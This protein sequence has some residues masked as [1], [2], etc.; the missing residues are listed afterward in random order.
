M[1][2]STSR[3]QFPPGGAAGSPDAW[4]SIRLGDLLSQPIR[5]GYSPVCGDTP[6]GRWVLGLGALG[7]AGVEPGGIK[8]APSDDHRVLQNELRVG[9]FLV[10]RSNT[11][12]KVGRASMWRGEVDH[13]SYP[14][15]MMRFRVDEKLVDPDYLEVYLRSKA[16]RLHFERS[17]SGTSGSM[18]KINKRALET[19]PVLLPPLPEQKR[20]A[21]A[22]ATWDRAVATL[23][24]LVQAKR[25]AH[26]Y[27]IEKLTAPSE[28]FGRQWHEYTLGELFAVPRRE[29]VSDISTERLVTVRLHCNG[30]VANDTVVPKSTPN[31]RQYFRRHTGE[32]LVGRQNLH[33]GGFGV[34]P[35]HLD[36]RIA[37]SAITSLVPSAPDFVDL[38]FV[39]FAM[40][41]PRWLHWVGRNADGTGQKEL[42]ER[43][44]LRLRISLP[45]IEYQQSAT[46]LLK[47]QA[48][49]IELLEALRAALRRQ[50]TGIES[51]LFAQPDASRAA[52]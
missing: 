35:K 25:L 9:D 4:R 50:R 48:R 46:R 37:S 34:M 33:N 39:V 32:L 38:G 47:A 43:Q 21:Q 31:G 12:D 23:A 3:A 11:R 49:E 52:S 41:R 30:V 42:S 51:A 20:I 10:S 7:E 8:P 13:C 36:G 17:A 24:C 44:L 14:D 6:T 40:S 18:V 15:L 22:L 5:N 1:S 26:R 27:W 16:A 29:S 2:K 28:H 19:L 45:P